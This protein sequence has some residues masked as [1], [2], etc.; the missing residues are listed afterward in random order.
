MLKRI[1]EFFGDVCVTYCICVLVVV[2]VS[3]AVEEISFTILL[4]VVAL[5][6]FVQRLARCL[7]NRR[8][9]DVQ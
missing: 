3:F 7:K 4:L 5:V 8:I 6:K 2:A 1:Y 9:K